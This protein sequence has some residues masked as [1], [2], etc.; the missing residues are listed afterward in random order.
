MKN[1]KG[2][3]QYFWVYKFLSL[4]LRNDKILKVSKMYE[5]IWL[6]NMTLNYKMFIH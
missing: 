5:K 2:K 6:S 3:Y 4:C 1:H